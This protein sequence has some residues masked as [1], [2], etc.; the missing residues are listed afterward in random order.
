MEISVLLR[1]KSFAVWKE[2]F[3]EF[4]GP[5][6]SGVHVVAIGLLLHAGSV[7][8]QESGPPPRLCGEFFWFPPCRA[9]LIRGIRGRFFQPRVN[10]G[11]QTGN[12]SPRAL[13]FAV[14]CSGGKP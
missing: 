3:P 13:R 5:H 7:R 12:E 9:R 1:W 8:S 14:F 4:L 2:F 11:Q 10:A 6:V